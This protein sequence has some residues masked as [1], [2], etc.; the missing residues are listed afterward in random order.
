MGEKQME[1]PKR[2]VEET[3]KMMETQAGIL[4]KKSG[5]IKITA[6]MVGEVV[7]HSNWKML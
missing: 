5:G 3:K 4:D 2:V 1:D 7:H 6:G